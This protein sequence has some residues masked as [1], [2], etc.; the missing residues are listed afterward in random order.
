ML[1]PPLGGFITTY[2]HW[3]WIFWINIP[4]GI[5]GLILATRYIEN[6]REKNVPPLDRLGFVLSGIGLTGLAFGLTTF[7]QS[8]LPPAAAI[9]LLLVGA[10][11]TYAFA[12]HARGHKNPLMNLSLLKVQTFRASVTGGFLFRIGIGAM[13]FLLPLLFQI[14]FGLSPFESGLLTFWG[15]T[16]AMVLRPTVPFILRRLGFRRVILVN[17]LIASFFVAMP[18]F[19]TAETPHLVIAAVILTGGF[20]RALQFSSVN[21]L[22]FADLDNKQMS[23]ATSITSVAQQ[24]AIATGVAVAALA[25]DL[26]RNARGDLSLIAADFAPAF[27][28]VGVVSVCSVFLFIGLPK[29]AGAALTAREELAVTARE[30]DA[31]G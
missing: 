24:L 9:P 13:A 1:G 20:F 2:F 5:L 10:I 16:G 25:L 28:F 4:I 30:P 31:P 22:A 23:Q 27:V 14:G 18:A 29:N 8:L 19:F 26:A 11:F 6:I 15:A 7:G 17:G 3:R 21:S 12:R